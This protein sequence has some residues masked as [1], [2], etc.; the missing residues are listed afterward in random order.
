M[1]IAYLGVCFSLMHLTDHLNCLPYSWV[2]LIVF[3][4]GIVDVS[5]MHA[6]QPICYIFSPLCHVLGLLYTG[7]CR[8]QWKATTKSQV[9]LDGTENLL[10]A[11]YITPS[12]SKI[13][14]T[15]AIEL[16]INE[17]LNAV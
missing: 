11:D 10:S 16:F 14:F 5:I 1:N 4:P 9:E 2:F 17:I 7:L 12:E 6:V 13:N 3:V 8:S 15:F